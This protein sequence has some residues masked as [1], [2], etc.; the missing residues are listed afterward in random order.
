MSAKT[1]L[2]DHLFLRV[3]LVAGVGLILLCLIWGTVEFIEFNRRS[4]N[5]RETQ[6]QNTRVY[7]KRMIDDVMETI[8]FERHRTETRVEASLRGRV[9][10]AEAIV[11]NLVQTQK[12]KSRAELESL[13]RE[14][15]RPIRFNNGRGYYFAFDLD[16]VEKLFPLRPQLEGVNMLGQTG[17][18]GE[19]VVYDML[20]VVKRDGGGLYRYYW[21]QPGKSGNDHLKFAYV[22]LIKELG[23]VVGTGE[24]VE[25]MEADIKAELLERIGHMRFDQDGYVFVSQWDGQSLVGSLKGSNSLQSPHAGVREG[26]LRL[27]ETAKAGGGLVTYSMT[28]FKGGSVD[29]TSYVAGVPDWQWFVGAGLTHDRTEAEITRQRQLLVQGLGL[30]AAMALLAAIFIGIAALL[31]LR[32]TSRRAALDAQVLTQAL[33][34]AADSPNPIDTTPLR[35]AE[36]RGFALSAN[37]LIARRQQVEKQLLDRT[38]ELE[39]TNADLE[40]FAYVA[41]HDLQEPL[42]T[43]GLFLQLLK[44]RLGESLDAEAKEYI[45]FA[46]GGADRMRNNI[47]GLLAYSR[48]THHG[49]T[50]TETDMDAL[51]SRVIGDLSAA[52]AATTAHME[53]TALPVLRVNPDQMSALFQNLIS[54][55]LRYRHPDRVPEVK[56]SAVCRSDGVWEFA[57]ADNGIGVP[58]DYRTAIFEPFRRFQPPGVEGGSGIG[59]ALC[60]RVV[61]AHGGKIWVDSDG[62]GSTFRFT[63]VG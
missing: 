13:A 9:D 17:A 7:L 39:Q 41:S 63:V 43:I 22:R 53:A 14:A 46:V 60:R 1:S 24:Y 62:S 50:R 44:R 5:L 3:T 52:I 10:E 31:I 42:R 38:A 4:D 32:A 34:A 27:I 61:E 57:V 21:P 56:I 8:A 40:R 54:N 16:G 19:F 18:R 25:D 30:K 28:D 47:Q 20:Q 55:A 2:I 48:S 11:A 37:Q 26:T 6:Q 36:H 59:L 12:G 49:D 15:L 23:W 29:K 51:L 35:F 33:A 45:D 58:D